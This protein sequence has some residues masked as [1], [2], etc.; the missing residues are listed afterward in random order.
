MSWF[1]DLAGKAEDLLNKMDQG[2]A[3]ALTKNQTRSSSFT[4]YYEGESSVKPEYNTAGYK[5]SVDVTH[6]AYASSDNAPS[7]ISAAAG[8]IKR[9][10]ATLLAGTTNM[11]S[12]SSGSD[13]NESNSAKT[14]SVFVRPKKEQGVDDDML[15]DFLNSSDTPVSNR[16]DSRRELVKVAVPVMEAQNPTPPPSTTPHTVPSAPSTPPS[17]RGVSRASSM[18]SLSAHSIKMSEESAA[19]EQSQGMINKTLHITGII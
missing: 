4:S 16:R 9:S 1:A 12:I 17:T 13:S 10:G 6:H 7:Y 14:S 19:K 3:T 11:T 2:A 15:F 18:S 5:T 8:N